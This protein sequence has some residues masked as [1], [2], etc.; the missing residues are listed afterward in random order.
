MKF[1]VKEPLR[2]NIYVL[3]RKLGY[4]FQS[5]D[6]ER[7]EI[8]FTRPAKGFPRFHLFLKIE[9]KNIIFNLHIDQKRP[10]YKGA[11]AHSGE[12]NSDIVREEAE[13]IKK[14]LKEVS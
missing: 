2:E 4:H 6:K 7:G 5:K 12:Y 10:I 3:T 8:V 14:T 11:P 1:I 9:D 13:R